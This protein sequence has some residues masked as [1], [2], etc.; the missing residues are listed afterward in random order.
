M[1]HDVRKVGVHSDGPAGA[2][3]GVEWHAQHAAPLNA[4]YWFFA[5]MFCAQRLLIIAL[6]LKIVLARASADGPTR[7]SKALLAFG[8]L[9]YVP[10]M[11]VPLLWPLLPQA[12]SCAFWLGSWL[13]FV[14]LL[15]LVTMVLFFAFCRAE[16]MR[17]MEECIWTTVS[18]IQ[19][20]FDFRR[21]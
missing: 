14:N 19:D 2:S 21:F 7:R 1:R 18:S 11:L 5:A 12:H 17:N 13:D 8:A 6:V 9:A 20:Q 3:R 4:Y 15:D 16:F 10:M